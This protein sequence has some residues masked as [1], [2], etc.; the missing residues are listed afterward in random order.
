MNIEQEQ[1]AEMTHRLALPRLTR[2][3]LGFHREAP[4]RLVLS[5]SV[6]FKSLA[7]DLSDPKNHPNAS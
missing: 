2:F 1:L 5:R 4:I 3:R 7:E 6:L